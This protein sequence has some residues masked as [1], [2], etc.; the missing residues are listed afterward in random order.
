V[1]V[2]ARV[3]R[4]SRR[5]K[6]SSLIISSNTYTPLP[7]PHAHT[8][9]HT[10]THTQRHT[11]THTQTHTFTFIHTHIYTHAHTHTHT[12]TPTNT[13]T[14]SLSLLHTHRP[15]LT[16]MW[17]SLSSPRPVVPEASHK[18]LRQI[19]IVIE[20]VYQVVDL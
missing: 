1:C 16:E 9:T 19:Q 10:H 18:S 17:E 12:H 20:S 3:C 11:H 15:L 7:T 8:H 5:H 14:L 13:L 6:P 2:C 4:S